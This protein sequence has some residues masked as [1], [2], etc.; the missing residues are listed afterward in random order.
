MLKGVLWRCLHE[1]QLAMSVFVYVLKLEGGGYYVGKSSN[2]RRRV[3]EHV[4]GCGSRWTQLHPPVRCSPVVEVKECT[5][6]L[7]EETLV[8]AYYEH[9]NGM[10]RMLGTLSV[11]QR[12]FVLARRKNT[13]KYTASNE[14]VAVRTRLWS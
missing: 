14:C 10:L 2:W 6:A 3:Q 12:D 7:D 8:S 9:T 4:D 13:C 11:H 5:H 1:P